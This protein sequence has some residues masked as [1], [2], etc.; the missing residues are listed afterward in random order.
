MV[1][2]AI[3]GPVL[4]LL[5]FCFLILA[6]GVYRYQQVAYLARQGAR[7][8]STHGAQYRADNRLATGDSLVWNEDIRANGIVPRSSG[9]HVNRLSVNT[10]WSAGD[11]STNTGSGQ[12]G[13]F[14]SLEQ[15]TV[16]VT[17]T[18]TWLPPAYIVGPIHMSSHSTVPMSY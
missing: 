4:F 13:D 14:N 1:E 15:N 12:S 8:A 5:L 7:Y 10:D 2:F 18:Y 17:V 11:N 6:L 16:T 9:L 3:I